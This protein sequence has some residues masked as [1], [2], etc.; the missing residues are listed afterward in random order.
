MDKLRIGIIG[1]GRMGKKHLAELVKNDCWEVKYLCDI[2]EARREAGLALSPSSIFTKN[3]NDIF[4][5]PSIDVV[6]L[7][8][9]ADG[10]YDRIAKAVKYGKHIVAEKPIA[11][12]IKLEEQAVDVVEKSGLVSATNLYLRNA[13]FTNEIKRF[14]KSGEIGDL[15]IIR[16]CHLTPGLAPGEGHEYEGP[17]FHDCG[18]HY[19]DIA[20]WFAESDF[21]TAHAQAIRMWSYKEPWWLQCHGT[22]TNGVVFDIT[23]GHVYGQ[24]SK[25]QTH[26]CYFDIIGTK[27]IVRMTHDFNIAV[28]EERGVSTTN[29]IKHPYGDKNLDKMYELFAK[30]VVGDKNQAKTLPSF[31]DAYMASKFAWEMLHDAAQHEL[32]AIGTLKELEE[33]HR[34][35]ATM[36]KGYG[37]LR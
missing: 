7:C 35:R 14:I 2:S 13:W 17:S 29:I 8:A 30:V 23:Q 19:V 6:A 25:E 5:D 31:R 16:V 15:A 1:V 21:K 24:L 3:E 12:S 26:N 4:L 28:V 10:R 37:L 22:F 36:E 33:I 20:R 32:P 11:S 18:M 34:R 27:G 9:L